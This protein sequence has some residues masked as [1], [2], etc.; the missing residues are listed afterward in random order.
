MNQR[1]WTPVSEAS[2]TAL[3]RITYINIALVLVPTILGLIVGLVVG[4]PIMLTVLALLASTVWVNVVNRNIESSLLHR[5][6]V[7]AASEDDHARLINVVDGLC[8]VSGDRRPPLLVVSDAYP[9]A[10]AIATPKHQGT[11]VVSQGFLDEMNRVEIEAVMAH[12]LWRLRNG[13]VA[14]TSYLI[15]LRTMLSKIGLRRVADV[16]INKLYEDKILLWSDISACQATRY[17]PALISALQKCNRAQSLEIDPIL[18]PLLFVDPKTAHHDTHSGSSFPIV[19]F[20]AI[21]VEERIA[22]LKEI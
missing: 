20:S 1:Q 22:V 11:V 8:V 15:A 7:V 9:I 10:L 12:V 3:Q 2:A 6:D 16:I 14:L 21:G 19:G 5:L 17:P 13:N 18:S 4:Q